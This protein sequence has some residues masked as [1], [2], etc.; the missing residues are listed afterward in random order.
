V[1]Y[2]SA[3][4]TNLDLLNQTY[5]R[6]SA[7]DGC[8]LVVDAVCGYYDGG[9]AHYGELYNWSYNRICDLGDD[10]A[11]PTNLSANG[12]ALSWTRNASGYQIVEFAPSPLPATWRDF[13]TA[14]RDAGY[15]GCC[16]GTESEPVTGEGLEDYT[17][18][19]TR[20]NVKN[21]PVYYDVSRAS[22]SFQ[23]QV[24]NALDT[25]IGVINGVISD[26]GYRLQAKQ[27]ISV[28]NSNASHRTWIEDT[29]LPDGIT[30]IAGTNDALGG[31]S[32]NWG[33]WES[34]TG[35]G[36][37]I[38]R[39]RSLVYENA[40]NPYMSASP[41]PVVLE[42]VLEGMGCGNDILTNPR[43]VFSD[44]VM[45]GKPGDIQNNT[46][47]GV[48]DLSVVRMTYSLPT[49]PTPH[50]AALVLKPGRGQYCAG[51]NADGAALSFLPP[52][53]TFTA[54]IWT[55]SGSWFSGYSNTVAF[56]VP[57]RPPTFAW[58]YAKTQGGRFNLTAQEWN[59]FTQNV[60]L[61]R[62][63]K[64]KAVYSFTSA[65]KG[66]IFTAAMYNQARAAIQQIGGGAG[67]YIPQVAAGQTITAQMVN[68]LVSEINV[69][70]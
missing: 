2:K 3:V 13:G 1:V 29:T 10:L 52:G 59:A 9:Y 24:K 41:L 63:Y 23:T 6:G 28:S 67:G 47:Q 65:V 7:Y 5:Y 18:G 36:G 8:Y 30:V 33:N 22:S 57:S 42:E 35:A 56:T 64:S 19:K 37:L 46:S 39:S 53:E 66:N 27:K 21:I 62:Q 12:A 54:R 68:V 45:N 40:E 38:F 11:A 32:Y 14:A 17:R 51:R 50:E 31:P 61:V 20:Y 34:E 60:N 43:S 49:A 55:A 44:F 26:Y 25:T 70:T 48:Y 15:E 4:T 16:Q 69:I 58:T